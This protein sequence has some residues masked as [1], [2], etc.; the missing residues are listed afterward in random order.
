MKSIFEYGNFRTFLADYYAEKKGLKPNFTYRFIARKVGFKSAGH[1]TQILKGQI[2]LSSDMIAKFINFLNLNK[3]ESEYFELL[4]RFDHAGTLEEKNRLIERM[5]EFKQVPVKV[6]NPDQHELYKKWYYLAVRDIL[7][8]YPFKGDFVGLARLIDPPIKP[9]EA[10]RAI[11]LL[12][13]LGLVEQ[14]DAGV[15]RQ[16]D[17]LLSSGT[18]TASVALTN[19]AVEMLDRAKESL[20]RLGKGERHIGGAGFAAS[21]ETFEKIQ[22]EVRAFKRR[23]LS[24][25]GSDNAPSRVYHVNIQVFP[26]SK[27]YRPGTDSQ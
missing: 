7:S 4:V 24:L 18:E 12:I 5:S 20:T 21:P 8:F 11:N 25:A 15:Y 6:I 1:F 3:K 2:N 14:D 16:K 27:D 23:I 22:E 9:A 26:L 13:R 10:R 19:Y 17:T